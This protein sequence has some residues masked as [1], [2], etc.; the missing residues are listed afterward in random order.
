M[1]FKKGHRIQVLITSSDFPRFDR[2][3]NT[4]QNT[5]HETKPISAK[6]SVYLGGLSKII[7]PVIRR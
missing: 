6:Q 4:G 3:P 1:V 7:L 5:A 2:N